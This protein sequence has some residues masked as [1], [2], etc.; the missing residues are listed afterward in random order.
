MF[1]LFLCLFGFCYECMN[2]GEDEKG[3]KMKKGEFL[4]VLVV[5][6]R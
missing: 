1:S 2:D 5:V 4:L 3:K 6:Y